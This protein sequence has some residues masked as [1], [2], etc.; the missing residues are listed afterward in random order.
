M[1]EMG[2]MRRNTPKRRSDPPPITTARTIAEY[3]IKS[4]MSKLLFNT[5]PF[6]MIVFY[7]PLSSHNLKPRQTGN[8]TPPFKPY[9]MTL[10]NHQTLAL[11]LY[12]MST[13]YENITVVPAEKGKKESSEIL[14]N[15][16]I[17]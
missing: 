9:S 4:F 12:R 1:M 5:F 2:S 17:A 16:M 3:E 8:C 13:I 14:L 7:F 6:S 10:S 11:Y 15:I